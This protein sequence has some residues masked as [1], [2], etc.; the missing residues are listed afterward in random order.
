[1]TS[2][3]RQ[4]HGRWQAI[5]RWLDEEGR[6]EV[7]EVANRLDVALE[8]VRRD[9]RALEEA[10]K[11]QRVHGGAIPAA[12]RPMAAADPALSDD[13]AA[14][15][16][17]VWRLL[18][19]A[20]S[21]LLGSGRLTTAVARA[22]AADPPTEPG[23]TFVTN[24]LDAAVVLSRVPHLSVYNIGGTVSPQTHAQEGDWALAELAKLH[25][26][27]AVIGP[28]GVSAGAGLCQHHPAA[29]AV[30]EAEVAAG[31]RT[32][33]L[34]GPD[35]LGA[36]ALVRFAGVSD[37]DPMVVTPTVDRQ[38]LQPFVEHSVE[39]VRATETGVALDAGGGGARP[40]VVPQ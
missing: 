20:G 3:Q 1:M 16:A 12:P 8:T 24:S 4:A 18:P 32:V 35:S 17:H 19:R 29:A 22:V 28:D 25:T 11:L 6:I 33:V 26:D 27:V 21:V 40:T 30:S 37:I 39:I 15:G 34:A 14:L 9:L 7:S 36:L 10:G 31:G 38:R 23:L 2:K 13:D 5:V